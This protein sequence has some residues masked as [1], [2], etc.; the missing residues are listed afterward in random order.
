MSSLLFYSTPWRQSA[1]NQEIAG[2][3]APSQGT[4]RRKNQFAL[5]EVD[6]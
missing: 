6:P 4:M 3:A 1:E 5:L 2:L